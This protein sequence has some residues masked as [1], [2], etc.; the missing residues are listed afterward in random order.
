MNYFSSKAAFSLNELAARLRNEDPV[1]A[2]RA[3]EAVHVFLDGKTNGSRE[4]VI[5]KSTSDHSWNDDREHSLRARLAQ[6]GVQCV[7]DMHEIIGE[8]FNAVTR[9]HFGNDVIA[10]KASNVRNQQGTSKMNYA[11]DYSRS[12]ERQMLNAL[13]GVNALA[14]YANFTE[15]KPKTPDELR[16]EADA[17]AEKQ[18]AEAEAKAKREAVEEQRKKDAA[19]LQKRYDEAKAARKALTEARKALPAA[20]DVAVWE[21]NES[22]RGEIDELLGFLKSI[23]D[24]GVSFAQYSDVEI[25]DYKEEAID[26]VRNGS[27]EPEAAEK[28]LEA[29]RTQ[30]SVDVAA[31][32][33]K[34][35]ASLKIEL[36]KSLA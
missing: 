20:K 34:A 29:V 11:G 10:T 35:V 1:C 19:E 30:L 13:N 4:I 15:V 23:E 32:V 5:P 9:T 28:A 18:K 26:R 2:P 24:K 33:R 21:G 25:T 27:A 16:K 22:I 36:V 3:M 31:A 17:L 7:E 8:H 12:I 14:P 6:H